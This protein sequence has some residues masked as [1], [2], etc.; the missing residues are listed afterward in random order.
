MI[1]TPFQLMP[2]PEMRHWW[3]GSTILFTAYNVYLLP[4]IASR[5][6]MSS[7]GLTPLNFQA[8]MM[9]KYKY[10]P[11]KSAR[12]PALLMTLCCMLVFIHF[13]LVI[14]FFMMYFY[15]DK[16]HEHTYE[17]QVYFVFCEGANW[18]GFVSS[19]A[20]LWSVGCIVWVCQCAYKKA[21]QYYLSNHRLKLAALSFPTIISSLCSGFVSSFNFPLK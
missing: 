3:V 11:S 4:N 6:T 8:E 20:S 21:G 18:V 7:A 9:L 2:H 17:A 14:I 19:L 5:H 10:L 12:F 1:Y 15:T 13:S 16:P